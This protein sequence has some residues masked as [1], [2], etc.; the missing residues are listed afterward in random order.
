[1]KISD[2]LKIKISKVNLEL[3]EKR[4]KYEFHKNP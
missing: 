4:E 2:V 3:G 1:M